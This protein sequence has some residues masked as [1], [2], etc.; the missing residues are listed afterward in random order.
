MLQLQKK[1]IKDKII[2]DGMIPKVETCIKSLENGVEFSHI[3]NGSIE[4]I[5]LMELFTE[6]GA[7]TMIFY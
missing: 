3:L 4:H 2:I 7:G 5:L 6:K 1:L